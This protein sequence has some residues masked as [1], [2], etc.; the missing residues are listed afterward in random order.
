MQL[1]FLANVIQK[2][3]VQSQDLI[4]MFLRS[5]K[6]DTNRETWS[7]ISFAAFGSFVRGSARPRSCRGTKGAASTLPELPLALTGWIFFPT[8]FL[9]VVYSVVVG[10]CVVVLGPFRDKMTSSQFHLGSINWALA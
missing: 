3:I 7:P 10:F 4:Y 5:T 8:T 1:Y 2:L 6:H 9:N